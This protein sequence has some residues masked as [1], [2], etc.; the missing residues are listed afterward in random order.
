MSANTSPLTH[1][2]AQGQA[3]M[4]DVGAKASTHRIAVA[5]GRIRMQPATLAR[6]LAGDKVTLEL[7]PYDLSKA[8]INFRHK[9]ER[10]PPAGAPRPGG[11]RRR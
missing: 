8:R 2:D 9:D 6:I 3:H 4:V 5:T 7:T 1:F 10:A 11:Y